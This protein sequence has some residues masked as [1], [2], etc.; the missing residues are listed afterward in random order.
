MMRLTCGRGDG[1]SD[2]RKN[3]GSRSGAPSCPGARCS[4]R[5]RRRGRRTVRAREAS[6]RAAAEAA[7]AAGRGFEA[8]ALRS[9]RV[10][11]VAHRRG[12]RLRVT[13]G[14]QPHVTAVCGARCATLGTA[15][16]VS[17]RLGRPGESGLA[18][19][20]SLSRRRVIRS[21][22]EGCR[23]VQGRNGRAARGASDV[24]HDVGLDCSGLSVAL[25]RMISGGRRTLGSAQ[26]LQCVRWLCRRR[27]ARA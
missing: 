9:G 7:G 25:S 1:V 21:A 16:R 24:W 26:G 2:A 6:E 12:V 15:G 27:G 17:A 8:S 4:G 20:L 22:A 5:R 13:R 19:R 11:V 14:G 3:R 18:L 23:E 10:A